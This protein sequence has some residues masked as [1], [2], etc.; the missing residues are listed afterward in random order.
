[1]TH[2]FAGSSF[3]S[4]RCDANGCKISRERL[5]RECSG[6]PALVRPPE[7]TNPERGPGR[8]RYFELLQ[9]NEISFL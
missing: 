9:C 7:Q 4:V 6:L 3:L 2:Q 5:W 8:V 1:M